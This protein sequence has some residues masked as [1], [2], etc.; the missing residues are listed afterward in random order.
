[1]EP[2]RREATYDDKRRAKRRLQSVSRTSDHA[3]GAV[4]A[5]HLDAIVTDECWDIEE[6][7]KLT[8]HTRTTLEETN[9]IV[10]TYPGIGWALAFSNGMSLDKSQTRAASPRLSPP[11][12]RRCP[13]P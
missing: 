2:N 3:K 9:R 1:M 12:T 8:R 13:R 4:P 6:T 7:A 11:T 5:R 10:T